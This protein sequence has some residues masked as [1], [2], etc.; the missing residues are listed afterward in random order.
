MHVFLKGVMAIVHILLEHLIELFTR[1][2]LN[3]P[4]KG[5]KARTQIQL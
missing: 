4:H 2:G 3:M 5:I 1:Q